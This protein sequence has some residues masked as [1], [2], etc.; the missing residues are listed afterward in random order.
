MNG[1]MTRGD[2]ANLERLIRKQERVLNAATDQR[3]AELKADFE[4]Q[5]AA[6]YSFDQDE[7][8]KEAYSLVKQ[9]TEQAQDQ[10]AK[11]CEGIGIPREFAP[12]IA[13]HWYRC[14]ENATK[15]RQAELR[16]KAVAEIDALKRSARTQI[17]MWSLRAQTDLASQTLTSEAAKTFLNNM[18]STADL[19]PKLEFQQVQGLLGGQR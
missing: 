13:C 7:V 3:A 10:V 6:R 8:W 17:E 15:D 9:I 11:R 1:V 5:M 2:I 16:K 18:P 12:S 14:G 4:A 19:M